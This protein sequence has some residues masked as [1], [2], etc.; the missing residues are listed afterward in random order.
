MKEYCS[1]KKKR[2]Y[3]QTYDVKRSAKTNFHLFKHVFV[4]VESLSTKRYF[5]SFY[6][7]SQLS[8]AERLFLDFITEEMDE[9]NFIV[10]NPITHEKFNDLL[11][12]FKI[13]EYSDSTIHK[14]FS[15]LKRLEILLSI[16]GKRGTFQINP[17]F[18]FNGEEE[19][20][21]SL[22]RRNLEKDFID[23]LKEKRHK[24]IVKNNRD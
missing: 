18:F 19:E 11:K 23:P 7:I 2:I 24:E 4:E 10:N 1:E 6:L 15:K 14:C 20:R 8:K 3:Y 9:S 22:I 5:N 17:L 13:K 12:S 21:E 16:K